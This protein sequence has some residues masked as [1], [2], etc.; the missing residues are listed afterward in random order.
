MLSTIAACIV[1]ALGITGIPE[2]G[3]I[4]LSVV[5]ATMGLPAELLP[6]L[7]AVDWIIARGRSAVN[8][9]SDM[10]L[11]IALDAVEPDRENP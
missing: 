4:S 1:A 2:A 6:L 9:L 5:I 11:S 8:V 3:F 10:T 7:L